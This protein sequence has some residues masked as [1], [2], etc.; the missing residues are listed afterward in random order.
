M[1]NARKIEIEFAFPAIVLSW[2]Y[3][4]LKCL[5]ILL[6]CR[7]RHKHVFVELC[8]RRW[9]TRPKRRRSEFQVISFTISHH[10]TLILLKTS[11][12]LHLIQLTSLK[13]W[14]TKI[15]SLAIRKVRKCS[16]ERDPFIMDT[17]CCRRRGKH[18]N[19]L[20]KDPKKCIKIINLLFVTLM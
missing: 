15:Q 11:T 16:S 5:K 10:K 8:R 7:E 19:L 14:F 12:D 18:V 6:R 4:F 3:D 1:R 2:N 17:L 13:V 20:E 9:P